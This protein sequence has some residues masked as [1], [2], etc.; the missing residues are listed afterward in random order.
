MHCGFEKYTPVA[1][2]SGKAVSAVFIAKLRVVDMANNDFLTFGGEGRG[3]WTFYF[4]FF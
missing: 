4:L 3:I 1:A 2:T